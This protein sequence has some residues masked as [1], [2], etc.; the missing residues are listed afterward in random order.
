MPNKPGTAPNTSLILT[1]AELEFIAGKFSGNKS[2]AIHAA[3]GAMMNTEVS[4]PIVRRASIEA[5]GKRM[6]IWLEQQES[7][8]ERGYVWKG[9]DGDLELS[10]PTLKQAE[11]NA[12]A[13]YRTWNLRWEK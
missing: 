10:A 2:A 1:E 6:P 7:Q 9:E 11:A 13:A 3:L 8:G 5:E 12:R 4:H